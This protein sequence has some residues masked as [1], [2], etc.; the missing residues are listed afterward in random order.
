MTIKEGIN[1]IKKH[2]KLIEI[3]KEVYR[4]EGTCLFKSEEL[5][6]LIQKS[7]K[8]IVRIYDLISN[9]ELDDSYDQNTGDYHIIY[10]TGQVQDV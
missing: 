5:R 3:Y 6:V 8:E 10:K 1:L 9:Y 4:T 7:N 2:K